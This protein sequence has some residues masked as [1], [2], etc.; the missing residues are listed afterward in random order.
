MTPAHM[1]LMQRFRRLRLLLAGAVVAA[2]ALWAAA[3][4]VAAMAL[5]AFVNAGRLPAG[6]AVVVAAAGAGMAMLWRARAV[7]SV[8]C[9]ALWL[10]EHVPEL[11]YALLTVVG[12]RYAATMSVAGEGHSRL[13]AMVDQADLEQVVRHSVGRLLAWAFGAVVLSGG[14]ISLLKASAIGLPAEAAGRP[15]QVLGNRLAKLRAEIVPPAY[16]GLPHTTVDDPT[17]VPGLYGTTIRFLGNG[18]PDGIVGIVPT[19]TIARDT[20][21]AVAAMEGGDGWVIPVPMPKLAGVLRFED[22]QYRRVLSL[23]PLVDSAP[24]LVLRAPAKDTTWRWDQP[25]KGQLTL[26]AEIEDDYGIGSAFFEI[27]LSTGSAETYKTSDRSTPRVAFGGKRTGVLR[28]RVSYQ[29]LQLRQGAVLHIRAIAYDT[30]D[31]AVEVCDTVKVAS[32]YLLEYDFS[33]R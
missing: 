31:V 19:D 5:V 16:S 18:P 28:A 20:V 10:E 3:A 6:V 33:A 29:E 11:K 7:W 4:G 15:V 22:R 21:P 26:E 32:A 1:M 13:V 14:A 30:N 25:P 9:V 27:L 23:E 8:E 17:A 24:R 2:A 12:S